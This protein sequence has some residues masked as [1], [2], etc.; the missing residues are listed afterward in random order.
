MS[1][2]ERVPHEVLHHLGQAIGVPQARAV[3]HG[4]A[5]DEP[6]GA[7]DQELLDDLGRDLV[8]VG[9]SRL[10]RDAAAVTRARVVEQIV[11][12]AHRAI[13]GHDDA[14]EAPRHG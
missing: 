8:Q 3:A 2:V 13:G 5:R 12:H 11:D 6:L 7:R 4:L 14:L 9:R 1:W 10:H